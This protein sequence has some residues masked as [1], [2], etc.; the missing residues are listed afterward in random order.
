[1]A[2]L[3]IDTV[4]LAGLTDPLLR[5]IPPSGPASSFGAEQEWAFINNT[6]TKW[7]QTGDK[8]WIMVV[9]HY[10]GKGKV[11]HQATRIDFEEAVIAGL[12]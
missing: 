12:T 9:G 7:A 3:F 1:M 4:I 8:K 10:P 11:R 5:S 6:L 2:I